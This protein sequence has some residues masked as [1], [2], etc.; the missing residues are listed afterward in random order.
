[1]LC[2]SQS[3][4]ETYFESFFKVKLVHVKNS[5]ETD[6]K[7]SE[8][9]AK[10]SEWDFTWFH[11]DAL[12][13]PSAEVWWE[14]KEWAALLKGLFPCLPPSEGAQSIFPSCPQA[15]LACAPA[16]WLGRR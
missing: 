12:C 11:L 3:S 16:A 7:I 4:S 6:L 10:V 5:S 8:L 9:L 1:M 2:W 15:G 14:W 13:M